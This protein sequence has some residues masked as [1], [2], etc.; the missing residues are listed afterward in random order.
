MREYDISTAIKVAKEVKNEVPHSTDTAEKLNDATKIECVIEEA[1]KMWPEAKDCS[2]KAGY[3]GKRKLLNRMHGVVDSC[4]QHEKTELLREQLD[5]VLN[6]FV[7]K[8][9]STDTEHLVVDLT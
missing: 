8:P 7:T 2:P 1:L 3:E 5:L 4:T 9:N 6:N